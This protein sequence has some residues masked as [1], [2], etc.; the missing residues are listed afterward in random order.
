MSTPIDY[1]RVFTWS[2]KDSVTIDG[3]TQ[4]FYVVVREDDRKLSDATDPDLH[5]FV[6][7][8]HDNAKC[9]YVESYKSKCET[10][11]L[12]VQAYKKV[13]QNT[14]TPNEAE[15]MSQFFKIFENN[16]DAGSNLSGNEIHSVVS[17]RLQQIA[18]QDLPTV[19]KYPMLVQNLKC[20]TIIEGAEKF[21]LQLTAMQLQSLTKRVKEQ[22][23][24]THLCQSNGKTKKVNGHDQ[25]L[26]EYMLAC[27]TV[28]YS[29]VAQLDEDNLCPDEDVKQKY[30][31]QL[32]QTDAHE[33]YKRDLRDIIQILVE[34]KS[35]VDMQL[36]KNGG[37]SFEKQR[38]IQGVV[39]KALAMKDRIESYDGN[40]EFY[41]QLEIEK[42]LKKN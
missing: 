32:K 42:V 20:E 25:R 9:L 3:I 21:G 19:I 17:N 23:A 13:Q 1:K 31:Q 36:Q 37:T 30:I 16:L 11:Q 33:L 28:A 2:T 41:K 34:S 18:K 40:E 4:S 35:K 12:I 8:L 38:R 22:T 10:A 7:A 39:N 24:V 26:K 27:P 14:G 6:D 29:V 15:S 5:P